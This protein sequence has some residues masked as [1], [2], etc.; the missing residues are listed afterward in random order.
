MLGRGGLSF[1]N[2][3]I[4][5]AVRADGT[6]FSLFSGQSPVGV[7]GYFGA[8]KIAPVSDELAGRAGAQLSIAILASPV[9][10]IIP[11]IDP[12]DAKAAQCGPVLADATAKVQRTRKG[13]SRDD[14]DQGTT[15]KSDDEQQTPENAQKQRK[16]FLGIF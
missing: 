5:M 1:P 7:G 9:G 8:P 16:K 4:D 3:A 13:K 15:A 14:V 11:F 6:T 2:E 12:R 10:L